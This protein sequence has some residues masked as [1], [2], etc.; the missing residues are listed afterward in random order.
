MLAS[1]FG[2]DDDKFTLYMA[3]N[4]EEPTGMT[5][6][7][8]GGEEP[9]EF[10]L[11]HPGPNDAAKDIKFWKTNPCYI[12][13]GNGF[14]AYNVE[15]D[16]LEFAEGSSDAEELWLRCKIEQLEG[17]KGGMHAP[18]GPKPTRKTPLPRKNKPRKIRHQFGCE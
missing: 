15:D 14:A 8:M 5:S 3:R 4:P 1:D 12:K 17:G 9:V 11:H 18:G 6:L 10:T 7:Q 13:V 2:D 16:W